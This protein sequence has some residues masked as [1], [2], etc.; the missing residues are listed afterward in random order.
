LIDSQRWID[1]R[2]RLRS[3]KWSRVL[4]RA[5]LCVV[6]VLAL[7]H[8]VPYLGHLTDDSFLRLQFARNLSAGRGYSFN[9]GQPTYGAESPL[10]ILL[11][12]GVGTVVPGS[13]DAPT[14]LATSPTLAWIAKGCGVVF[15][16]FS[17]FALAALGRRLGWEPWVARIPAAL[18]AGHSWSARWAISGMETALAVLAVILV[19]NALERTLIEG[20]R[21]FVAGCAMGL[22]TLAR[23]ECWL[24]AV[25]GLAAVA[26]A[27]GPNRA[28]RVGSSAAG[29]A[30][31][32]GPWLVVAWLWF[33]RLMPNVAMAEAGVIADW[34]RAG[35]VVQNWIRVI[36]SAEAIP[37]AVC[38]GVLAVAGPTILESMSRGRRLFWLAVAAWPILLV[39]SVAAGRASSSRS[40]SAATTSR[41]GSASCSR[42][43]AR[44]P[45]TRASWCSTRPPRASTPRPSG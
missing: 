29:L 26:L 24:L 25:A 14:T 13:V 43:R 41:P 27:G 34:A 3:E 40:A 15:L 16:V 21:P 22:A 17:I 44:S 8:L 42:S 7:V 30:L 38:V 37:I 9:A 31:F 4:D 35:P 10:W 45:T 32:A 28:R 33:H 19:L 12:A 23:P 11:I 1:M 36:L 20:K 39:L 6:V 2:A 18:I 5:S